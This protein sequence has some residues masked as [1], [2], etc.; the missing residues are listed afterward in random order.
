MVD[1]LILFYFIGWF[2]FPFSASKSIF[3]ATSRNTEVFTRN[4]NDQNSSWTVLE[5]VYFYS[6]IMVYGA[7]HPQARDWL[8][9]N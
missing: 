7:V 8:P 5:A 3:E 9:Q 4:L 6:Y 1:F 2:M